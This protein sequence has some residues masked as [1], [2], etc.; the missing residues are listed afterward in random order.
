MRHRPQSGYIFV[1][2]LVVVTVLVALMAMLAADQR[3]SMQEVENRLRLRRSEAAADAAVA[4]ALGSLQYANVNRVTLNDD[5]ALLGENGDEEFNLGHAVFRVQIVDAGSLVNVNT[6]TQQQLQLLPLDQNQV[7]CLLDW[8][9]SKPDPRT[10]GAKDGY[11]NSLSQP[12]NAKLGLLDTVDELL[13]VK[14]WTAQTLYQPP[15]GGTAAQTATDAQ[16]NEL[17]L[18]ALVTVDSGAL[19]LR[20]DGS[21]RINMGQGGVDINALTQLGISGPIAGQIAAHAPFKTF[22]DL[23]AVPGMTPEAAG[24]LLDA[25]TFTGDPR[26]QGKINLNTASQ[27]VLQTIPNLTSD[28]ASAI[29]SQQSDGFNSLSQLATVAGLTPP[30]LAQV[31]DSF[32]VGGDTWIVRAYGRSGGVGVA[33]EATVGLRSGQVQTINW[34]RL[35]TAGIPAWWGWSTDAGTLVDAGAGR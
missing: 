26:T 28:V 22:Q 23:L 9:E 20:A 14:G 11:Y 8:R 31:A 16:G 13:L 29:V 34:E 7:D 6:A 5:W 35:S 32:T 21:P 2:A 3:A 17:P 15:T 12:Y 19:N 24:Q 1:Q 25:A 10:D 30:V 18:A 27:A 4:R 33:V